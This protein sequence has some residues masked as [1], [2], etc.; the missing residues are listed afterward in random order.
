MISRATCTFSVAVRNGIRFAFWI[1]ALFFWPSL[2]G[3]WMPGIET[4]QVKRAVGRHAAECLPAQKTHPMIEAGARK[5]LERFAAGKA[6]APLKVETPVTI[7][8]EF[9][10][11]DMADRASLLPGATRVGGSKIEVRCTDMP[12]AYLAFRAAVGLANR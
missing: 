7:G 5:A 1:A 2:F 10:Y 3:Q 11:S 12:A 8:V 6:S 4:V 9:I